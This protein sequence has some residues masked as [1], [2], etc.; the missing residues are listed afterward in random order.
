M[1][2]VAIILLIL[3]IAGVGQLYLNNLAA[4]RKKSKHLATRSKFHDDSNRRLS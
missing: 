1:H 4:F 3:V 2:A